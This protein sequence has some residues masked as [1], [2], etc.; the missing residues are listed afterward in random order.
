MICKQTY[1]VEESSRAVVSTGGHLPLEDTWQ[2]LEE[3]SVVTTE[4]GEGLPVSA[5]EAQGCW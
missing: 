1:F 2:C 3:L 4:G 5:G